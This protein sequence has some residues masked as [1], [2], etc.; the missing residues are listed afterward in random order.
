MY[1]EKTE[2][3][4]KTLKK[5]GNFLIEDQIRRLWIKGTSNALI[6]KKRVTLNQSVDLN[7]RIKHETELTTEILSS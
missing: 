1:P 7:Q 4:L 2:K 6:V 3:C 5:I